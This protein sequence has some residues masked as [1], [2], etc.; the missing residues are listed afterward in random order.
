MK[1]IVLALMFCAVLAACDSPEEKAQAHYESGLALLDEGDAARARL[2]FRNALQDMNTH[3]EA[4]IALARL[5]MR[6]GITRQALNEYVRVVEQQPDNL[7]ALIAVS[8][9]A[10]GRQAWDALDR[11]STRLNSS[12]VRTSRMPSSA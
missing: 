2:E 3:L 8:Q 9:L 7:E 6:E 11:K 12:H 1:K 5:N 4:R 10:F